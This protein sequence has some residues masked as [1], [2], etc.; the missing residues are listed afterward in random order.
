VARQEFDEHGTRI[1]H[2]DGVE[3]LGPDAGSCF[4]LFHLGDA[5]VEEDQAVVFK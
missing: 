2:A 1:G 5:G 4:A 3:A